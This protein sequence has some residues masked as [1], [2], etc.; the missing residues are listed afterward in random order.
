M[1]TIAGGSGISVALAGLARAEQ[2]QLL[3]LKAV[4]SGSLDADVM[5]QAAALLQGAQG[6]EAA[7][8]VALKAQLGQ[9]SLF[10]DLLA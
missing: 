10:I 4:G 9:Q 6:Q 5:A 1:T 3:A 8:A 2:A 7:S